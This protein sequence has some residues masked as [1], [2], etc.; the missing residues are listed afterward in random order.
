MDH[1]NKI[2][3]LITEDPDVINEIL[4]PDRWLKPDL[5]YESEELQRTSTELKIP[6]DALVDAFR[7]GKLMELS[8]Q[9]LAK[10]QNTDVVARKPIKYGRIKNAVAKYGK[11]PEGIARIKK[12][13]RK[14]MEIDAPVVLFRPGQNP[15]LVSG[16]TRLLVANSM[17]TTPIV[18]AIKVDSRQL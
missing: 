12:L 7:S 18:W 3:A 16:N 15:Y 4:R 6:I 14:G 11:T 1:V 2:A 8:Q 10:L 5:E 9:L 13:I 17:G